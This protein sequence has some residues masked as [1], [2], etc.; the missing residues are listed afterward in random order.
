MTEDGV[1]RAIKFQLWEKSVMQEIELT[2]E[3][4]Q[5]GYGIKIERF[6]FAHFNEK[7]WAVIIIMETVDGVLSEILKQPQALSEY[8]V[9]SICKQLVEAVEQMDAMGIHHCDLNAGNIG[10]VR[11]TNGGYQIKLI[12]FGMA[13]RHPDY[14]ILDVLSIYRA[15]LSTSS[16]DTANSKLF[17]QHLLRQGNVFKLPQDMYN[18]MFSGPKGFDYNEICNVYEAYFTDD[19]KEGALWDQRREEGA[20]RSIIRQASQME[21]SRTG[22]K[23]PIRPY[24]LKTRSKRPAPHPRDTINTNSHSYTTQQ[25]TAKRPRRKENK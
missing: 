3:F 6:C 23:S 13:T 16:N 11:Q 7:F 2:N 17:R 15:L 5:T 21:P 1:T 19:T 10:F 18:R 22:S 14:R 8:H 20:R 4:S 9:D 24:I 25:P 12:D